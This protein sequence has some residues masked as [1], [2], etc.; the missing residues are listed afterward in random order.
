MKRPVFAAGNIYHVYN[1]GT[2]KRVIFLDESDYLRAIHDLWEFNDEHPAP[3]LSLKS[4][5]SPTSHR[6]GDRPPK[7]IPPKREPRKLLVKIHA[8]VLMENHFHLLLEPIKDTGVT[9]FMRKFGTGYTNYIN[10]KYQRS[11]VLFQGKFKAIR[12]SDEAH[13]LHIPYYIH[14]NPLDYFDPGWRAG[15]LKNP[16]KALAFLEQY[17]WSSLPDYIGK[18]NFPSVSSRDFLTKFVGF[19]TWRTKITT[20]LK[21]RRADDLGE[22]KPFLFE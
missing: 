13:F 11:G 1:R 6:F 10:Q 8:F 2:D 3:H 9:E 17:R 22:M 4:V 5:G 21:D 16:T 14:C 15:K 20:W 18:K 12:I 7:D 19:E